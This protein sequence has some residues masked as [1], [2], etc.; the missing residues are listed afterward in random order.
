MPSLGAQELVILALIAA[1]I[2]TPPVGWLV[3]RVR[4]AEGPP[5]AYPANPAYWLFVLVVISY[6][7]VT[8]V[9][10]TR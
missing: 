9:R 3:R 8:A 7:V 4:G 2:V 6:V 1:M 5:S 10:V